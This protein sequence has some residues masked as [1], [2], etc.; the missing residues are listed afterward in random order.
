M[1]MPILFFT[2][3]V[4]A[5][6]TAAAQLFGELFVKGFAIEVPALWLMALLA[7]STLGWSVFTISGWLIGQA[8]SGWSK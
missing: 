6:V 1:A 8:R 4:T 2:V 5:V 7:V 3:S